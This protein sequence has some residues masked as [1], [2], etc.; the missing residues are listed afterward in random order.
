MQA[1]HIPVGILQLA[2]GSRNKC[3]EPPKP[4]S[5]L[6]SVQ[7]LLLEPSPSLGQ[8]QADAKLVTKY[9]R[10]RFCIRPVHTFSRGIENH[11][12]AQELKQARVTRRWGRRG[13]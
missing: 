1:Q 7:E 9:R 2:L 5:I 4:F 6:S 11:F 10:I 8:M 13:Q 12:P 3:S